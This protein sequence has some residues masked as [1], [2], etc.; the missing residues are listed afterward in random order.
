MVLQL[1]QKG[2]EC[3]INAS[4]AGATLILE[5]PGGGGIGDAG[6]RDKAAVAADLQAGLI[7]AE[8]ARI[9][10]SSRDSHQRVIQ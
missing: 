2:R 4:K 1:I 9:C 3:A 7:S 8:A 10:S 5:T 6:E